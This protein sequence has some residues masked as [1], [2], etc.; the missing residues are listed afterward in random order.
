MFGIDFAPTFIRHAREAEQHTLLNIEFHLADC[1]ELPFAQASFDFAVAFMS[2]MDVD[3][4]DRALDEAYRVLK[5]GEFLQFSILHPCFTAIGNQKV[6]DENGHPIGRS[7]GKYFTSCA[8]EEQ[9]WTFG[10]APNDI[11]AQHAKFIVPRFHRPISSWI[12]SVIEAGFALEA[13]QEPRPTAAEVEVCSDLADCRVVPLFL[14]IR[15]RKSD[16]RPAPAE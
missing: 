4:L 6:C 2:L 1:K 15:A 12:N 10:A 13:M 16:R 14:H 7:S 8:G 9:S 5:P 3:D 11:K